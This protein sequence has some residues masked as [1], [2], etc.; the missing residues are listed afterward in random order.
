[1]EG[2]IRIVLQNRTGILQRCAK[3]EILQHSA[4]FLVLM[5]WTRTPRHDVDSAHFILCC[6]AARCRLCCE[7][8]HETSIPVWCIV[9]RGPS[10]SCVDSDPIRSMSRS[11]GVSITHR[12]VGMW[13]QRSRDMSVRRGLAPEIEVVRMGATG[14]ASPA[15]SVTPHC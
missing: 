2:K 8:D 13:G 10:E 7:R 6:P 9:L 4:A 1:M 11:A 3:S 12:R 15:K 5:S 14:A